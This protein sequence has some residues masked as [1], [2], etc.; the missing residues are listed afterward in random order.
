MQIIG[1]LVSIGGFILAY[2]KGVF[3]RFR[4]WIRR[5]LRSAMVSFYEIQLATAPNS[6]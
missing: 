6:V 5:V 3:H 4:S 2:V 1:I